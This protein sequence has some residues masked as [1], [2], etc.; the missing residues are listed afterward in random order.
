MAPNQQHGHPQ[1]SERLPSELG[2]RESASEAV[3][4]DSAEEAVERLDLFDDAY[5]Q[6]ILK[7]L[8]TG[9]YCGRTLAER[10]EFSRP[11]VYRR[12]NRLEDAGLVSSTMRV[13]P[14]G[15]HCKEFQL[16]RDELVLT[17]EDGSISLTARDSA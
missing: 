14:D 1:A 7:H 10:C 12:L 3:V 8:T 5:A 11:T 13:D 2:G 6:E 15:D 17:V 4:V 9:S 16:V